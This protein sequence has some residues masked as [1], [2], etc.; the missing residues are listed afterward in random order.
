MG[1][2]AISRYFWNKVIAL[3]TL[4]ATSP[5]IPMADFASGTIYIPTGSGIG[6]LTFYGA[7]GVPGESLSNGLTYTPTYTQMYDAT[8]TVVSISVTA[9]RNY[10]IPD[11]A[12]GYGCMRIVVDVAGTVDISLKG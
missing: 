2:A 7:R 4:L 5:D 8:N 12:F 11:Q 6:T 10:P 9:G 3:T 1:V